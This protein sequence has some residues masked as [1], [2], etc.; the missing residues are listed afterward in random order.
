MDSAS[1]RRSLLPAVTAFVTALY[2]VALFVG[3]HL[4]LELDPIQTPNPLDKVQ[5]AVAFAL[6]AV[7]LC[8]VG[9]QRGAV[10]WRLVA[11]VLALIALYGVFDEWTQRFVPYREPDLRDW[12]ADMFGTGLG[13]AAFA[14]GRGLI[15]SRRRLG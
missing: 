4:P 3:S 7:L 13:I 15:A 10:G 2:W 8:S 1:S 5:H 12:L 11:G 6:L 9:A 14:L